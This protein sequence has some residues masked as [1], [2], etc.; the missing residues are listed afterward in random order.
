V[1]TTTSNTRKHRH[2]TRWGVR[3]RGRRLT[4]A[5]E[6]REFPRLVRLQ[7]RDELEHLLP[8]IMK[9]QVLRLLG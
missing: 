6:R 5:L 4:P 2:A 1:P 3:T 8:E 7:V 9:R